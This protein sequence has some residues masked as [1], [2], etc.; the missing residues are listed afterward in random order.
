MKKR[1]RNG[2]QQINKW[3]KNVTKIDKRW[4]EGEER[5]GRGE[6]RRGEERKGERG[7][8]RKRKEVSFGGGLLGQSALGGGLDP[9]SA[10]AGKSRTTLEQSFFDVIFRIDFLR[11][12]GD[13]LAPNGSQ[14]GSPSLQT[15][16]LKKQLKTRVKIE[17]RETKDIIES[18]WNSVELSKINVKHV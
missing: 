4:R 14:N 10:Q 1:C 9:G 5:R 8:E 12:L 2:S 17:S 15:H 13:T 11:Y 7:L 18:T 3:I 6:E 16:L